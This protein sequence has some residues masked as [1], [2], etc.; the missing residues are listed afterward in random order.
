MH[1]EYCCH[2][3]DFG[4]SK[5]LESE[6]VSAPIARRNAESKIISAKG[7]VEIARMLGQRSQVLDSPTAIQVRYLETLKELSR[8]PSSRMI[9]R[10]LHE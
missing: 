3:I 5:E 7:Q 9:Y 6:L 8:N 10:S 2:Y 1:Q 4:I